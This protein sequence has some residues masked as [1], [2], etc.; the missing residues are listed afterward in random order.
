MLVMLSNLIKEK[1]NFIEARDISI[2]S[3]KNKMRLLFFFFVKLVTVH[4]SSKKVLKVVFW[5][6]SEL[7]GSRYH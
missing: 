1:K 4:Q 6:K 7:N 2:L 3:K 5:N